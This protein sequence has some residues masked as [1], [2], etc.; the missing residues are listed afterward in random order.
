MILETYERDFMTLLNR[1]IIYRDSLLDVGSGLCTLLEYMNFNHIVAMDIHRPYLMNRQYNGSHV[2][3]LN[4]DANQMSR[5]FVPDSVSAVSFIDSIE[6]FTKQEGLALLQSADEIARHHVIVFTP[7]GYFPQDDVDHY[8][9]NGEIFQAHHSGWEAE[10]LDSL[11]YDV[12]IMKQFHGPENL[13][14]MRAFGSSHAPVDAL[15][16]VKTKL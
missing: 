12:I 16:A 7:R 4:A 15:L 11:G 13:A 1:R 14:F 5:L 8:G 3:P 2:I 10:E 6:H 9:M